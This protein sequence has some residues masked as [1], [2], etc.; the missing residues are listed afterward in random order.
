[1]LI[2]KYKPEFRES[3]IEIFKSN[4]PK[5]FAEEEL[6]QFENFLDDEIEEN[7]YVIKIEGLTVGCGGIFLDK[8]NDAAGLS[9]GMVHADYHHKGIGKFFT[10]YRIDMLKKTYPNITFKIE[11]SQHTAGFYEKRGFKTVDIVPDGFSNGI[12]KYTMEMEFIGT[13]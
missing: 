13:D 6:A 5:Y 8:S 9:W 11:T 12:D 10:Q 3:C 2:I 1:M 7:Y 4:L